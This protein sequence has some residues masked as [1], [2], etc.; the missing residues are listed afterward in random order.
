[1]AK[2]KLPDVVVVG[3]FRYIVSGDELAR[4]RVEHA[5]LKTLSGHTDHDALI[6]HVDTTAAAAPDTRRD[7][8]LHE[9]LHAVA[10]TAGISAELGNT[11]E[12]EIIRRMS[13]LL[14]DTLR[15]N[16]ALVAYILAP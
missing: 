5:E 12:E 3:P 16:P 8:L 4:L 11:K 9:V 7:T 10:F 1:M 2:A 15:R 6:V 13:P 14:L